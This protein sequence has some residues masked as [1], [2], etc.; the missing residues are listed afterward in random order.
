MQPLAYRVRP[1]NFSEV[2][3][4][5]HL[6]GNNGI[7]SNMLLKGRLYSFILYGPA[8]C[9]KTTIA[10]IIKDKYGLQAF[11]FNASTDNK[12]DLK[13][14]VEARKFYEFVVLIIDEIHRMKKDIQD[15]LLPYLED[16]SLIIIGL[17]TE[18]PYR[19][20]NPAIRS[21]LHIYKMHELTANDLI[22]LLK[23]VADKE[24]IKISDTRIYDYI[25]QAA[26]LE[27]R[28]ALNMLEAVSLINEDIRD[29][30]HAKDVIGY[31]TIAVD[32]KGENYYDILSALIKS[33]RGSD[34]DASLHYLVRFLACEDLLMLTR[35][36]MISAYEDIGMGNPNVGPRVLAACEVALKVGLP[37]ARIP[38]SFAVVDLASSP[39]SNSTYLAIDKANQ[40]L[41]NLK[42]KNIPPHILNK[43]IK[44]GANYKYPHDYPNDFV[45]QQ[46]LPDELKNHVYYEP[47]TNSKYEIALKEYLTKIN[48]QLK[49]L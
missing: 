32:G 13:D 3:G 1:K 4:Q 18:N 33:I 5:D 10:N 31:K 11:T 7:I 14:I 43:E 12:A 30:E 45:L 49:S 20:I 28:T 24:N 25:V 39:K 21:R 37:E 34:V 38:L 42:S 40:D 41:I 36:L 15:Y 16:G 47:K 48:K 19:V 22:L 27:V 6:V 23:K 9:G 44:G 35:R 2:I 8:G 46:Y 17:T 26:S 29:L